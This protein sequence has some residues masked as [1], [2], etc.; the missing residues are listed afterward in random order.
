MRLDASV[1]VD[2]QGVAMNLGRVA[3]DQYVTLDQGQVDVES[4]GISSQCSCQ[5]ASGDVRQTS[6]SYSSR[7]PHDEHLVVGG[8]L[9]GLECP[10]LSLVNSRRGGLRV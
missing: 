4:F 5:I 3:V 9:N 7:R 2:V 1:A 8:E 10:R 6:P